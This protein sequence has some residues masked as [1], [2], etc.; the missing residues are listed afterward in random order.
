ML[1]TDFTDYLNH[2]RHT[3]YLDYDYD[4]DND[5]DSEVIC[6]NLWKER[7]RFNS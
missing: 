2:R 1:S 3:P 4:Y 7:T 5:N 6:E